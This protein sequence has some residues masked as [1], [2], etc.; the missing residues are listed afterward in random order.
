MAIRNDELSP[1]DR[2]A[3]GRAGAGCGA[4][5]ALAILSVWGDGFPEAK[6]WLVGIGIGTA[7]GF[8]FA[9]FLGEQAVDFVKSLFRWIW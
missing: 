8:L 1:R 3:Y 2:F 9:W 6:W 5:L 7:A 4:L